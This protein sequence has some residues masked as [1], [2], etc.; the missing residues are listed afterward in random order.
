MGTSNRSFHYIFS[1]PGKKFV[2]GI[3]GL[4]WAGFVF[5][6]MAGNLLIFVSAD[7]YN[8]YGHLLTSSYFIYFAEAILFLSLL[9]HVFCAVSLTKENKK[10]RGNSRYAMTP[11]GS[12]G[13]TLASKTMA[14]QGSIILVFIIAHLVAFK[15]GTYYETTVNGVV[16]RDL[17]RLV[18]EVFSNPLAVAWYSLALIL[19]GFHLSHG[20]GSIFQSLGLRTRT[21]AAK[22]NKLSWTYAVIVASGFLAQPLY[23]FLSR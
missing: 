18:V 17:H 1:T 15:F 10:A 14:I 21:N 6:H 23:V 5:A 9:I 7:A 13:V 11:S 8:T 3:T 19:L 22:L 4:I 12:K 16:M 20:F 2:M